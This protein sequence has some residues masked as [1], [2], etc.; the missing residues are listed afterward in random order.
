[1]TSKKGKQQ[2]DKKSSTEDNTLV[3][4]SHKRDRSTASKLGEDEQHDNEREVKRLKTDVQEGGTDD[5][6]I[7]MSVSDEPITE[8]E[9][10]S[11][12]TTPTTLNSSRVFVKN[13][14]FSS[15]EDD[16]RQ[17]F[18]A[19]G[20]I[21]KLRLVVSGAGKFR[22]QASIR[23]SD[24]SGASKAV[25]LNGSDLLGRAITVEMLPDHPSDRTKNKTPAEAPKIT[26]K[27]PHCTTVFVAKF[28]KDLTDQGL[29]EIFQKC[30][31]ILLARVNKDKR[32]GE[33]L[34]SY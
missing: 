33:S 21:E 11:V 32:T 4:D 25:E 2:Y 34:V 20:T 15:T 8:G 23:F 13:L 5:G 14:N 12:K 18:S 22:G 29:L 3:T 19:C 7:P 28:S 9:P 24:P 26:V 6:A 1:M 31:P 17:H 27:N 10:E 30:G 16:V